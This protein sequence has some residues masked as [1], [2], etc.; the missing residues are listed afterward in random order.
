[1]EDPLR[2]RIVEDRGYFPAGTSVLRGVHEERVVGVMYGQRALLLQAMH[3]VAFE[4]LLADTKGLH[5]PFRRLVR[6]ANSME[7]VFFG[8]RAQ[9]D[10]VAAAV[11]RMHARVPAAGEQEHLLWILA[12]LADSGLAIH[13]RFVGRLSRGDRERYW[14]EYLLL[15]SLFGVDAAAAPADHDAFRDYLRERLASPELQV[16]ERARAIATLVAFDLPVPPHRRAALAAINHAIVGT[17]PRR[18]R[19][20]YGLSWGAVDELRLAA[21][22]QTLRA[23]ALV[24]PRALWTGSSRRDYEVVRRGEERRLAAG[25]RPPVAA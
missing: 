10:G 5:A 18:A 1:M 14:R 2:S 24:V 4:G 20:Q 8:T 12:C 19:E 15:G 11:A 22:S 13:E 9:A 17:L 6:T 16:S 7:R 23:A 21:L 3:P 25:W